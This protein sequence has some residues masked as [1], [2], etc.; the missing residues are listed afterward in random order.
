MAHIIDPFENIK[1]VLQKEPVVGGP[2]V[3]VMPPIFFR[4]GELIGYSGGPP[5][6]QGIG[7]DFGVYNS[8]TPNRFSSQP[9][10]YTSSIYTTAVCPFD[11]FTSDIQDAYKVKYYLQVHEG[12]QYDLPHFCR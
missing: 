2:E 11:Y 9:E 8:A 10:T 1:N 4:A 5:H 3:Q 12:M 6:T 7:F